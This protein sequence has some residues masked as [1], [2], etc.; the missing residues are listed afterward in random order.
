[1]KE[2]CRSFWGKTNEGIIHIC[3][4]TWSKTTLSWYLSVREKLIHILRGNQ[5]KKI[6]KALGGTAIAM[7]YALQTYIIYGE[8]MQY[9]HTHNSGL[10]WTAAFICYSKY[11]NNC[12][13]TS[14]IYRTHN[15]KKESKQNPEIEEWRKYVSAH[16]MKPSF[17]VFDR[18][19]SLLYQ[20]SQGWFSLPKVETNENSIFS[21][22]ENSWWNSHKG[23]L[24]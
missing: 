6:Y 4:E 19:S 1:M 23:K 17:P 18:T 8:S 5:V 21:L 10:E 22:N 12:I 3:K 16:V 24:W 11:S 20:G 2:L 9:L 13:F 15:M 7:N 14:I